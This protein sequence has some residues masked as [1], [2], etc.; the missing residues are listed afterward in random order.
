MEYDGT[1]EV[2]EGDDAKDAVKQAL[3][4]WGTDR[5]AEHEVLAA[6]MSAVETFMATADEWTL[7]P[8]S[9]QAAAKRKRATRP[10]RAVK[11]RKT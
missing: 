9:K 2:F 11:R 7:T 10:K 4:Q 3:Q 5:Y 6:P 1:F 8:K